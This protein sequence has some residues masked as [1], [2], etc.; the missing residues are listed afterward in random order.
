MKIITIGK[1][2]IPAEQI[3]LFEPFDPAANPEFKPEK[4]FKA[5]VVLV[6]RDTVL[7]E[8]S[9]EDFAEEH[10]FGLLAE[11]HVAINPLPLFNVEAF[12]PT[13]SFN[14]RKSHRTRLKWRDRDGNEQSKL[15]VTEPQNVLAA[16]AGRE[17]EKAERSARAPSRPRSRRASAREMGAARTR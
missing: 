13:E 11:D 10:G 6:N 17:V 1:R 7:I 16:I 12:T 5:R 8:A 3:A 15:L 2:L 4:D 14:P 9:P